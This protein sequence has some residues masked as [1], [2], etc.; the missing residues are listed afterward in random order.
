MKHLGLLLFLALVQGIAAGITP[1]D[2]T[3]KR[4]DK[5]SC[6]IVRLTGPAVHFK[7]FISGIIGG[8][9]EANWNGVFVG[10]SKCNVYYPMICLVSYVPNVHVEEDKTVLPSASYIQRNAPWHLDRIDQASSS[11]NTGFYYVTTGKGVKIFVV[12]SGIRRTHVEFGN[13]VEAGIC[14]ATGVTNTTDDCLGHGTA[15][16]SLAAGSTSGAAKDARIIPVRVFGCEK[17]A[18]VTDIINGVE[19][20]YWQQVADPVKSVLLLAI[21]TSYSQSLN[22]AVKSAISVGAVAVIAAGA[23]DS[24]TDDSCT[25]SPASV[26]YGITVG[27][28]TKEDKR[29]S[30]SNRGACIDLFAPGDSIVSASKDSDTSMTTPGS[31]TS[32]AAAIT[33]GHVAQYLE[34]NPQASVTQTRDALVNAATPDIISNAGSGSPDRLLFAFGY[35]A[36]NYYRKEDGV[37]SQG[38][39]CTCPNGD[40][41]SVGDNKD[42]CKTLACEGGTSGACSTDPGKEFSGMKVT[43]KGANAI[44][45]TDKQDYSVS[46]TC[47]NGETYMVAGAYKVDGCALSPAESVCKGGTLGTSCSTTDSD[48]VVR[49]APVNWQFTSDKGG[50]YGGVCTCPDGTT[51]T[52]GDSKD[53]CTSLGC[54]GGTVTTACSKDIDGNKQKVVCYTGP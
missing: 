6:Y 48:Y 18:S 7:D 13:R 43:C 54:I 20:V 1:A 15:V 44:L 40:V 46:C 10:F 30:S 19:W 31:G 34:Y 22:D 11:L 17:K 26:D 41:Y 16:A 25:F 12:D 47:P 50:D 51:Y 29:A 36:S 21:Q 37:G 35:G 9:Q 27:G 14:L 4:L 23:P 8:T 32:L 28:S 49:C 52:V 42:D 2:I 53:S 3:R 45:R 33:A 39:F 24:T 5:S 38:G